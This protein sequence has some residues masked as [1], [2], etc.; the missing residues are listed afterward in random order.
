MKR[1]CIQISGIKIC[2]IKG[3]ILFKANATV[4]INIKLQLIKVVTIVP[5]KQ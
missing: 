3:D 5:S 1:Y 2:Y 4:P